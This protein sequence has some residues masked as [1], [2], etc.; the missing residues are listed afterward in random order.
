[1]LAMASYTGEI[2]MPNKK[3]HRF[4]QH[5]IAEIQKLQESYTNKGHTVDQHYWDIVSNVID[6]MSLHQNIEQ[7]RAFMIIVHHVFVEDDQLLMHV[8]GVGGTGK[9]HLISAIVLFFEEIK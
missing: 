6:H 7:L 3:C 5:P 9:S 8:S 1:M 4:A 2:D